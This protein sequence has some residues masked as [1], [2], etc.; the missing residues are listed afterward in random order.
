MSAKCPQ[1]GTPVVNDFF[2]RCG[3]NQG[4]V[5]AALSG[6]VGEPNVTEKLKAA[7]ENEGKAKVEENERTRKAIGE[8][9]GRKLELST[10]S[11]GW[12]KTFHAYQFGAYE[13]KAAVKKKAV[14]EL[15]NEPKK[16]STFEELAESRLAL[17][18]WG[19][20]L[21]VYWPGGVLVIATVVFGIMYIY[22]SYRYVLWH[23]T[24]L[25]R[26]GEDEAALAIQAGKLDAEIE[27][28]RVRHSAEKKEIRS[29]NKL[30]KEISEVLKAKGRSQTNSEAV[31]GEQQHP[32]AGLLPGFEEMAQESLSATKAGPGKLQGIFGLI[33]AAAN[34]IPVGKCPNC[35]ASFAAESYGEEILD[36]KIRL[37]S[38]QE[39]NVYD[40]PPVAEQITSYMIKY[41]CKKCS[42][43]WQVEARKTEELRGVC[44]NCLKKLRHFVDSEESDCKE[45]YKSIEKVDVH[46]DKN[47]DIAGKTYRSVD[48]LM[49]TVWY[50]D[51]YRCLGCSHTWMESGSETSRV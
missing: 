26:S 15:E 50:T 17:V 21:F 43:R 16:Y 19:A 49:R 13:P 36:T 44:P 48:I 11:V 39:E 23:S 10:S 34:L 42:H 40:G 38:S 4:A 31:P 35:R 5:A 7:L 14:G 28:L 30:T 22:M 41:R 27:A 32:G 46:V 8:L 33:K 20:M 18:F 25:G 51:T 29:L 45:W 9:L 24:S 37:V 3:V 12:L 1:C 47:Y 6:G 2:C